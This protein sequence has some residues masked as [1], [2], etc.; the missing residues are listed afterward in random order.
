MV[1]HEINKL[2]NFIC[3]YYMQDTTLCDSIIEW[4]KEKHK[5]NESYAGT[6]YKNNSVPSVNLEAKVS[7]DCILN[8]NTELMPVYINHLQ[9]CLNEYMSKYTYCQNGG[10]FANREI[11]NIQYYPVNGGYFEWHTERSSA[12][13]PSVTRHLVFMTYLN[14]VTD[15]GETEFFHQKLKV[16]P[17]KGL[18]L[19]W[20]ADWT[21]THRGIP[22]PSQEKYI[23]TG[24]MNYLEENN[25]N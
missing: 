12:A 5:N 2:D 17:E 20:G 18:T 15:A 21:F 22:S 1:E 8:Q 10:K 9:S 25:G 3:G 6:T 14:D 19:I 11:T 23:V 16:K 24:W 7:F 4:F 13:H